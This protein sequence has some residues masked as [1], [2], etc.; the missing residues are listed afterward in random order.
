MARTFIVYSEKIADQLKAKGIEP[1]KTEPNKKYPGENV[2]IFEYGENNKNYDEFQKLIGYTV[3]LNAEE[4]SRLK[5]LMQFTVEKDDS[6]KSILFK[7]DIADG[8]KQ[9]HKPKKE[10]KQNNEN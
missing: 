7:L 10:K 6:F 4:F 9:K 2:C 5:T 3:K 8:T 1:I